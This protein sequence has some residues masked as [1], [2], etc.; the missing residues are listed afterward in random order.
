MKSF[1]SIFITLSSVL[2]FAV[3][4][5]FNMA[6]GEQEELLIS[7][8]EIRNSGKDI[9][10]LVTS[11]C[12]YC[13]KLENFL[14]NNDIKYNRLDIEKD[15]KALALYMRLG[16]GGVPI[17]QIGDS[18]IKGYSPNAILKALKKNNS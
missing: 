8:S 2:V 17:V 15:S 1:S 16:G 9:N 13:K 3:W 11:G 7:G 5:G 14:D 12:P 10:I 4:I 18:V 6:T